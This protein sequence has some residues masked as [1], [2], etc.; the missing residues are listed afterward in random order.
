MVAFFIPLAENAEQAERVY[1]A[2]RRNVGAPAGGPRIRALSWHHDGHAN[3]CEVGGPLPAY[4]G[5][6]E[7][8]VIAIFDVGNLYLICT[9]TRGV[10][11]GGPVM[12]GKDF[13]T[14]AWTFDP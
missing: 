3:H 9:P 10:A 13:R 6:G 11:T 12:A 2:T 8:P 1:E 4:Y 5:T 14:T 7:E